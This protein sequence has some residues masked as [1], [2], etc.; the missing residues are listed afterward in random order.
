MCSNGNTV[1][2][3]GKLKTQVQKPNLGHPAP[4]VRTGILQ[5]RRQT[6]DPGSKNRTW[7]T[8][9]PR[10]TTVIAVL[11]DNYEDS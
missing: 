9:P 1:G 8:R 3:N 6:Q 4:G 11:D 10:I 7:G 2:K 5:K